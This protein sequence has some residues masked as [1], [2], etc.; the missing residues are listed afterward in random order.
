MSDSAAFGTGVD[1]GLY[2]DLRN[3]PGWHQDWKRVYAFT[4]EVCEEADRLGIDSLWFSEHHL[5]RDGYLNQPL[6]YA[7]AVAART[8]QAR[9]STAV[10]VAPLRSSAQIAEDAA[11]VDLLSAGRLELGLGTGYRAPEFALYGASLTGRYDATD[12]RA[13]QIRALWASGRLLPPPVQHRVPVWMGYMGPKGARRAGILG[14][15]L[16][17]ADPALLEPY[18]DGLRAGGHDPASARMA[19]GLSAFTTDDPERDWAV[20]AATWPGRP[21]PTGSTQPKAQPPRHRHP[22]TRNESARRGSRPAFTGC[23]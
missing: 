8:R 16:L 13:R 10:V 20:W 3:P 15:G 18:V 5:F 9:I 14:E 22:W 1:V 11:V 21:T 19:G 12:E 2:F 6:T 4:L 17:A 7:A 23:W